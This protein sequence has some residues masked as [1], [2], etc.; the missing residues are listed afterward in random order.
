MVR[1]AL[2]IAAVPGPARD[3]TDREPLP[4]KGTKAVVLREKRKRKKKMADRVELTQSEHSFHW[5]LNQK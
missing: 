5:T 1:D 3:T 4:D 2:L